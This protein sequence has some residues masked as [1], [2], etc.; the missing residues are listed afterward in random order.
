MATYASKGQK[1]S[2]VAQT[3]IYSVNTTG[4]KDIRVEGEV[5]IGSS[6]VAAVTPET[7]FADSND[8]EKPATFNQYVEDAFSFSHLIR[9]ATA[10]A[11]TPFLISAFESGGYTVAAANDDTTIAAYSSTTSYTLTE[12]T[13]TA[14]GEFRTIELSNGQFLPM[15]FAVDG[16]ITAITGLFALPSATAGGK[17]V[18]KTWTITPGQPAPIPDAKFLTM[19]HTDRT[20]ATSNRAVMATGCWLA[21]VGDLTLEP[22]TLPKLELKFSAADVSENSAGIETLSAANEFLDAEPVKVTDAPYVLF[23]ASTPAGNIAATSA[24]INKATIS[25]GKTCEKIDGMGGVTCLNNVQGAM[26]MNAPCSVTLE[27]I[28][29]STKLTDWDA[30]T[31]ASKAIAIIQPSTS[32]SVPAWS[33]VVPNAH[34]TEAV[35]VDYGS[36]AVK[37]IVKYTGRPAG[38]NNVTTYNAQENQPWYFGIQDRSA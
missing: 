17:A 21:S 24:I 25:F 1:L 33:F 10:A 9:M 30:G 22:G 20:N 5:K 6:V 13:T 7:V 2:T 18:K 26:G 27:M 37:I 15:L 32:V 8:M 35:I 36:N 11:G 12:A 31:N 16:A 34:I 14:S 4:L 28:L 3:N 19:V 29:D 23:G 38:L